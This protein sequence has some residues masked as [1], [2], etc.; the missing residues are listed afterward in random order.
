MFGDF[1]TY[2]SMILVLVVVLVGAYFT[3]RWTASRMSGSQSFFHQGQ[4]LALVHRLPLGRDQ[5]LVIVKVANRHVVLG[6]TPSQLTY[7][8]ELTPE[9]SVEFFSEEEKF[10][11]EKKEKKKKFA[12]EEDDSEQGQDEPLSFAEILKNLREKKEK[13]NDSTKD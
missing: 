9:E 7:I 5:Q 10:P 1:L 4:K 8:T 11:K 3:T 2:L 12:K 13:S 6:C